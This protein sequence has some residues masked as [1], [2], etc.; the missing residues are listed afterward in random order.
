MMMHGLTKPKFKKK[1]RTAFSYMM[2]TASNSLKVTAVN[3]KPEEMT[4]TK[5]TATKKTT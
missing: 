4:R 1:D 5:Q 3:W 2:D